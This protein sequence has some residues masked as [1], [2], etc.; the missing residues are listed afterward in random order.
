M[1]Y[2]AADGI[3]GLWNTTAG[4]D[5]TL[6]TPGNASGNYNPEKTP[7]GIFDSDSTT[8]YTSYG[9]CARDNSTA[10]ATCGINTGFY[11][12]LQSCPSLLIA[13]RF[14]TAYNF[15]ECDPLV[16]TIE[17]SNRNSSELRSGTSWTLIYTGS[18]GLDVD[19]GRLE[20]GDIQS[21]SN[22]ALWFKN[23]RI[24]VTQK[25]NISHAVQYADIELFGYYY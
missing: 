5:S 19:P 2:P 24:L 17:G 13:F 18:T 12:T 21:L 10:S 11:V 8:V 6:S 4:D 1:L 23:Y 7:Q 25:R 16:L 22:N 15:A 3:Y 20:L 14:R 9:S